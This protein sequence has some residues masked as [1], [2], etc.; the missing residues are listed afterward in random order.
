MHMHVSRE[1]S[2]ART[3]VGVTHREVLPHNMRMRICLGT[4]AVV[5]LAELKHELGVLLQE[6]H[7]HSL[8]IIQAQDV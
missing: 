6:A 3:G 5:P 4:R 8:N 2:H 1:Q 7:L